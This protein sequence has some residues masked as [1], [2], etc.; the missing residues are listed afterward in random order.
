MDSAS[1]ICSALACW[2][3]LS[4]FL[5]LLSPQWRG[6]ATPNHTK[7]PRHSPWCLRPHVSMGVLLCVRAC[8]YSGVLQT[9]AIDFA[10]LHSH[11]ANSIVKS[12]TSLMC[13][14]ILAGSLGARSRGKRCWMTAFAAIAHPALLF[15]AALYILGM[16][17]FCLLL[18]ACEFVLH[19]VLLP[20]LFHLSDFVT[21]QYLCVGVFAAIFPEPPASI[22][23]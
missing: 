21:G 19:L 9:A 12:P 18:L 20:C 1:S 6:S 15:S 23:L 5:A 7:W 17:F 8:L 2:L 16:C 10:N 14:V 22:P 3:T 4:C 11:T 13:S